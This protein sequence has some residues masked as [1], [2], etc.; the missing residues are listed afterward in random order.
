MKKYKDKNV[1]DASL[2][3]LN[4]IFDNFKN[5]LI[6]F[7]G[8]KDSGVVLNLALKVAR[9]RGELH[10]LAV[11]VMDYEADYKETGDFIERTLLSLPDEVK[12]YWICLPISALCGVSITSPYWNPW[13]PS[14]KDI[15]V[16]PMPQY[17]FV[18]NEENI[19][20]GFN[21]KSG[22]YGND[23]GVEFSRW[24]SGKHGKTATLIGIRCD[25]SLNR[26]AILTSGQ[27]VNMFENIRWSK[28]LSE[29]LFAF[30][31][32]YDWKTRDI[33]IANSRFEWDYNKVYDLMHLAGV[34]IDDMRV[35]SPFHNAGVHN[36]H[37]FKVIDPNAWHRM[38]GRVD[39][40]NFGGMYGNTSMMGWKTITKPSHFTWEEYAKFLLKT[41]PQKTRA[42]FEK[43][44][45]KSIWHWKEQGGAR[46]PE[47]IAHL[48]KEGWEIRKTDKKSKSAKV[49]RDKRIVF[50]DKMRDDTEIDDFYNAPSWKRV[51]ITILKNDLT[52]KTMGFAQTKEQILKQRETLEKYKNL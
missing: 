9:E 5:V 43:K 50:I 31:P 52:C 28:K 1:Y 2:E 22:D 36:L 14:K 20:A 42:I 11:F 12:K 26:L 23:V 27:R 40:V 30:Y 16:K 35:A 49:N 25:E 41:L 46:S 13:D 17:D 4:F 51:V 6:S 24:F 39:G 47:F 44:I 8:G 29:N 15:W 7:S 33:W 18:I 45:E 32:I 34:S 19:P 21:F 38:L 10:K 3:R 48:E 37:L